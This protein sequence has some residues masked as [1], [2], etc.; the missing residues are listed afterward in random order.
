[1]KIVAARLNH[2]TNTFSP[3]PTPL[4]SFGVDGPT[5]GRAAFDAARG[6]LTGLGAFIA[7]AEARGDRIE[8]AVSA[9]ANP[10][11]A[12][13]RR[14]VRT[15]RRCHLRG[16]ARGL[17]RD[18]ARP[19]R[20]DGRGGRSTTAKASCS[21]ACARSRPTRRSRS[22]SICTATS[23]DRMVRHADIDRRLQ[24]LPAR[25]HVRDRRARRAAALR[26]ARRP[27]PAGDRDGAAG[28]A[29]ADAQRRTPRSRARCASG[30]MRPLARAPRACSRRRCSAASRWPTFPT[31]A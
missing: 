4:E 24:D 19:A 3:V 26:D 11:R 7:A 25:G 27:D 21:S 2:E 18:P 15:A 10:E 22:P 13:R 5:F 9:T 17:R 28:R 29:R 16:G 6:T 23:R 8:V 31:R 1:M 30:R 20:R 12:C 14:R